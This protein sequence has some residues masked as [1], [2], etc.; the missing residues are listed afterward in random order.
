MIIIHAVGTAIR[1]LTGGIPLPTARIALRCAGITPTDRRI[2]SDAGVAPG[3]GTG[4]SW[5][6]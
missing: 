5:P 6:P 3:A 4:V 1:P 2:D